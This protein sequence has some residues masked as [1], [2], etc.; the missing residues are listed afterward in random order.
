MDSK[1][2]HLVKKFIHYS[3]EEIMGVQ[4][5]GDNCLLEFHNSHVNI[6]GLENWHPQVI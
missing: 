6:L 4:L 1:S 5:V 3:H 2:Q